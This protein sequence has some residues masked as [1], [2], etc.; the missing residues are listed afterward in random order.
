MREARGRDNAEFA[1]DAEKRRNEGGRESVTSDRKSP[2]FAKTAKDGAPSSS[3]GQGLT[4]GMRVT[5]ECGD[6]GYYTD[7]VAD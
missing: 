7:W 3:G 5:V 2:S 6:Y 4:T 1:E